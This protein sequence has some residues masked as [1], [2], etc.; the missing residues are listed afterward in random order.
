MH[1]LNKDEMHW[2]VHQL[3]HES[4][5]VSQSAIANTKVLVQWSQ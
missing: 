5:R 1:F 4:S 2:L 3:M